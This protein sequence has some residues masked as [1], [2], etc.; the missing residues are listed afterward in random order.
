MKRKILSATIDIIGTEGYAE[1]TANNLSRKAGISK[2]ALY[3]HFA[4]LNEIRYEALAVLIDQF[5]ETDELGM[6]ENLSDFLEATGE[7]LFKSMAEYPVATKALYTYIIQAFVDAALKVQLQTLVNHALNQYQLA[8]QHFCPELSKEELVGM[9]RMV[10]TF[11]GGATL[12]YY[13]L[14]DPATCRSSW[15]QFSQILLQ[16]IAFKNRN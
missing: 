14:E 10:D 7:V 5:M 16:H 15:H 8:F 9:V 1:V 13:I 11:L 3:H 2:G 12:Q 6:F 4:N